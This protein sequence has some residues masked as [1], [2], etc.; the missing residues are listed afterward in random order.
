MR[1][2]IKKV[3]KENKNFFMSSRYDIAET[4]KGRLYFVEYAAE[5]D[6]YMSFSGFESAEQLKELIDLINT[7]KLYPE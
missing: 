2:D 6:K 4:L 1:N 7:G 3:I 5:N